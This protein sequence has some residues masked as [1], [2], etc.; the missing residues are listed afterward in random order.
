MLIWVWPNFIWPRLLTDIKKFCRICTTCQPEVLTSAEKVIALLH[1]QQIH[2]PCTKFC[3]SQLVLLQSLKTND[4]SFRHSVV[5]REWNGP[6]EIRRTLS[7]TFCLTGRL[8]CKEMCIVPAA[9]LKHYSSEDVNESTSYCEID[10]VF[11]GAAEVIT[12]VAKP[13]TVN[14][15]L[16]VWVKW[17][18][19][20]GALRQSTKRCRTTKSRG[21]ALIRRL[22]IRDR[23][24]RDAGGRSIALIAAHGQVPN[25]HTVTC[26]TLFHQWRIAH[27]FSTANGLALDLKLDVYAPHLFALSTS[28]AELFVQIDVT[29]D[30]LYWLSGNVVTG[31]NSIAATLP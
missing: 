23:R 13:L 11:T 28:P 12:D 27:L 31:L 15:W 5:E 6:Y 24:T 2:N 8:G 25:T 14:S 26:Y 10:S 19:S 22:S 7:L 3:Q 4:A 16:T 21:D 18:T 9:R 17:L 1:T 30:R 20:E 29:I